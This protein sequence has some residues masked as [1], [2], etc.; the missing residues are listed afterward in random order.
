MCAC[1][2][3]RVSVAPPPSKPSPG[4]ISAFNVR[5]ELLYHKIKA[6]LHFV[7]G[8]DLVTLEIVPSGDAAPPAHAWVKTNGSSKQD[9]VGGW[10]WLVGTMMHMENEPK[11]LR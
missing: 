8:A 2:C 7:N 5:L 4:L 9:R 6:S 10:I 11:L 1:V 3:A